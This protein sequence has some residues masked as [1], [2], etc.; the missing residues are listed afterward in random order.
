LPRPVAPLSRLHP[1]NMVLSCP[2]GPLLFRPRAAPQS[3]V[4]C[5]NETGRLFENRR[6]G[7]LRKGIERGDCR[8]HQSI[9]PL[10]CGINSEDGNER[11]LVARGVLTR[12][13]A[14]RQ[15]IGFDIED[16]VG[17]LERRA[18]RAA[19]ARE[20]G[21]CLRSGAAEYSARIDRLMQQRAGFHRLKF[22]DRLGVMRLE[23]LFGFEVEHLTADHAPEPRCPRQAKNKLNAN[24]GVRV[25]RRVRQYVEGVS[26]KGIAD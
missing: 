5:G 26:E 22:C 16:I 6:L 25:C 9:A 10:P 21:P 17:H 3:V 23:R 18:K 13:L 4:P 11:C 24:P 15:L 2:A 19:I 1:R 12:S 14:K 8:R 7:A 20:C